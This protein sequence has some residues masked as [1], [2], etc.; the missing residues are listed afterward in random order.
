MLGT[1]HSIAEIREANQAHGYYWF[2]HSAMHSFGTKIESS[3]YSGKYFITSE[4]NYNG[5]KRLYTIRQA[6]SNGYVST[7]ED[8]N[9]FHTLEDAREQVRAIVKAELQASNK[10]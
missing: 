3:V 9:K 1:F 10:E 6:S 5:T 2:T 4:D 7:V 8:F